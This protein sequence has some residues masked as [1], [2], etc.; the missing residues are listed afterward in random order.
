LSG[1]F[2]PLDKIACG[3]VSDTSDHSFCYPLLPHSFLTY[4]PHRFE[5]CGL[6]DIEFGWNGALAIGHNTGGL[7]K[8]PG[9]Y[10]EAQA[11]H[12]PHLAHKLEAAVQ[13]AL[14]LKPSDRLTMMQEALGKRFPSHVMMQQ[15]SKAWEKVIGARGLGMKA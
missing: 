9:V 6:V 2:L 8:M 5:P 14:A 10:F 11:S 15:Y 7:G 1:V 13:Q 3:L 12:L 4:G